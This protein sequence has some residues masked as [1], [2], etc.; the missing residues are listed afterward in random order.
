ME[1]YGAPA[2]RAHLFFREVK[3]FKE[4]KESKEAVLRARKWEEEK[5]RIGAVGTGA[6]KN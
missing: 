4:F 6:A 3:E 2:N 1:S 5:R